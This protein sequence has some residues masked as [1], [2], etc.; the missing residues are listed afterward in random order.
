MLPSTKA[1]YEYLRDDDR[2]EQ[3]EGGY[4][5]ESGYED[6]GE[7]DPE[8]RQHYMMKLKKKRQQMMLKQMLADSGYGDL[9]KMV[10]I[11]KENYEVDDE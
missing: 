7:N 1:L 6:P 2:G 9:A 8:I 3:P 10:T 11:G 5:P 4:E